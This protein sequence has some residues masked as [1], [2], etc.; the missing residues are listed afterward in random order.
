[1][2]F[3]Q[4]GLG[5]VLHWCPTGKIK[6][7]KRAKVEREVLGLRVCSDEGK[8]SFLCVHTKCYSG[9]ERKETEG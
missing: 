9:H 8:E 4:V 3:T 2:Y 1:M 6:I 7:E 5:H